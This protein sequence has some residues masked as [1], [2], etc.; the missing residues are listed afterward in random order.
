ME[1][2]SASVLI[3]FVHFKIFSFWGVFLRVQ[4][5][6]EAAYVFAGLDFLTCFS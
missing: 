6:D 2:P 1:K 4:E 5:I 3:K